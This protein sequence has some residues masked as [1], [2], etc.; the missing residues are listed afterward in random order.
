M[1]NEYCYPK[2]GFYPV[3]NFKDAE[4]LPRIRTV[5][6]LSSNN[7]REWFTAE[8]NGDKLGSQFAVLHDIGEYGCFRGGAGSVGTGRLGQNL[9]AIRALVHTRTAQREELI[10]ELK[11]RS[12]QRRAV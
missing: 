6:N 5:S 9:D 7:K 4:P 1:V 11:L 2:R 10:I 12:T 3:P 8:N